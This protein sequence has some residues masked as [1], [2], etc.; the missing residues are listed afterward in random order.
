MAANGSGR[1]PQT[2]RFVKGWKGGPGNPQLR[3]LAEW[4]QVLIDAVS[5]DDL[6]ETV[7]VLKREAKAGQRWAVRE[8]LDRCLGKPEQ[9][10]SMLKVS[11]LN[12]M[13]GVGDAIGHLIL[14]YLPEDRREPFLRELER[15]L[16]S[17]NDELWK[18]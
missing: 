3:A 14:D 4:R 8:L 16:E 6:R 9:V 13:F 10:M 18:F 1:D 11:T 7:E 5:E 12:S 17:T 15:R 2:G